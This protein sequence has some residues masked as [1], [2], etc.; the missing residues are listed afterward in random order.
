MPDCLKVPDITQ[1]EY[2]WYGCEFSYGDPLFL[3]A[4]SR[5]MSRTTLE[6]ER[7]PACLTTLMSCL[8]FL[9][10]AIG[11]SRLAFETH[12]KVSFHHD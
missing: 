12:K 4:I 7:S 11:V 1:I 9:M 10:D 5:K 6:P 8:S 3:S 2:D